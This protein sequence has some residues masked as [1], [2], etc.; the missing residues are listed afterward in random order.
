M[1]EVFT[2]DRCPRCGGALLLDKDMYAW[3]QWCLQCGY[4]RELCGDTGLPDAADAVSRDLPM[5]ASSEP[6]EM[7]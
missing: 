4:E 7:E 1:R 3:Q 5:G 6:E 2:K